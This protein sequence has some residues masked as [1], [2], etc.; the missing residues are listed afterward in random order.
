MQGEPAAKSNRVSFSE[1]VNRTQS[2]EVFKVTETYGVAASGFEFPRN[3]K[4][5]QGRPAP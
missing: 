3:H 2:F 1:N 5:V 4:R